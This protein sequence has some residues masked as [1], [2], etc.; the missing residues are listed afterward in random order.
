MFRAML[1]AVLVAIGFWGWH[2]WFPGPEQIIR[3]RL[4]ELA[5]MATV[6]ANEAPLKKM[7][8]AQSLVG[9]FTRDVQVTVDVPGRSPVYLNGQEEIRE[10]ALSA[11]STGLSF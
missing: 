9:Y 4:N 6:N 7:A 11:R 10:A 8:S 5:Q 3:R 2:V 1:L